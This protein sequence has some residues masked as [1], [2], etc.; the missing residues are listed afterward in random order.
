V[1]LEVHQ[2]GRDDVLVTRPTIE[3]NQITETRGAGGRSGRSDEF[4]AGT[5]EAIAPL[6]GETVVVARESS[7][8]RLGCT[9]G[10]ALPLRM[11]SAC[12]EHQHIVRHVSDV[13]IADV[14]MPSRLA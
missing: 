1:P 13:A 7:P 14:A 6:L 3:E 10:A 12:P 9:S 11:E 5:S 2:V 4:F 8:R